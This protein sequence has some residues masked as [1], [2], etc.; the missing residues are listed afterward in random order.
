MYYFELDMAWPPS[1]AI[2]NFLCIFLRQINHMTR[3]DPNSIVDDYLPGLLHSLWNI[4]SAMTEETS[5]GALN[6]EFGL[7]KIPDGNLDK[8]KAFPSKH[9]RF[10]VTSSGEAHF[11]LMLAKLWALSQGQALLV[12]WHWQSAAGVNL[13]TKQQQL[14]YPVP[15]LN[16]LA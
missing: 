12:K 16:G 2:Q 6:G 4:D 7:R 14:S 3:F 8:T 5:L 15:W 11:L 13:S 9:N 10:Q 1:L